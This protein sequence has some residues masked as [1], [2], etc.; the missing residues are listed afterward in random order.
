MRLDQEQPF[1]NKIEKRQ[2]PLW[3]RICCFSKFNSISKFG[4]FKWCGVDHEGQSFNVA[5]VSQK[6]SSAEN[7]ANSEVLFGF[8]A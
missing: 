4:I 8:F 2:P 1:K 7:A 5:F 6:K 3:G